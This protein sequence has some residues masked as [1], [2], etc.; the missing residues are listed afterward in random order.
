M[1]TETDATEFKVPG[2]KER[3]SYQFR[4]RAVNKAGKSAPSA[5]TESHIVKHKN[6]KYFQT[7]CANNAENRLSFYRWNEENERKK[8][9]VEETFLK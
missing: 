8:Y 7:G 1:P 4:V 2:L 9:V 3:M 5:P 6:R